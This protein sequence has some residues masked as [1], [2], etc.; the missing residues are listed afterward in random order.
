[1]SPAATA[2]PDH[3]GPATRHLFVRLEQRMDGSGQWT[4]EVAICGRRADGWAKRVYETEQ[5]A[6]Q[7]LACVEALGLLMGP[8]ADHY[9][10][11]EEFG[12][13]QLRHYDLDAAD[14]QHVHRS[15]HAQA[16][17]LI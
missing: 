6:R 17:P 9:D 16:A 13:W 5:D 14:R 10:G 15:S 7:T 8:L 2:L 3:T 1:L 4:L 11:A 12:R